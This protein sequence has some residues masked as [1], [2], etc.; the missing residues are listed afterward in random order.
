MSSMYYF[1]SPSSSSDEFSQKSSQ[2][3]RA[4]VVV[5]RKIGSLNGILLSEA[6]TSI[7]IIHTHKHVDIG[8][9]HKERRRHFYCVQKPL[10]AGLFHIG[11]VR[12]SA[13]RSFLQRRTRRG[14]KGRK[15][16]ISM[17]SKREA[18]N[19]RRGHNIIRCN[20]PGVLYI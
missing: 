20:S 3:R 15:G 5:K 2:S 19:R 9:C 13:K 14:A 8:S 12:I 10:Y 6:H 16:R 1:S 11:I 7:D 18:R 4:A 17:E